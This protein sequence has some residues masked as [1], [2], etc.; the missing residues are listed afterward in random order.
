MYDVS[1]PIIPNAKCGVGEYSHVDFARNGS[2]IT[3][4]QLCSG[5]MDTGGVGICHGDSGGPLMCENNGTFYLTGIVSWSS[6][7]AEKNAPDV[8]TRVDKYLDWIVETT[9]FQTDM[10]AA[11]TSRRLE[12]TV[13]KGSVIAR[14]NAGLVQSEGWPKEYGPNIDCTVKISKSSA[15]IIE[16][17]PLYFALPNEVSSTKLLSLNR[18]K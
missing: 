7:C 12:R 2:P 3:D 11:A 14:G 1:S 18:I 16:L 10:E 13:C 9:S 4:N 8:L 17:S 5:K 6:G 15:S